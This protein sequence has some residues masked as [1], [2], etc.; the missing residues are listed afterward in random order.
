MKKNK[1]AKKKKKKNA[2]KKKDNV[3]RKND[4]PAKLQPVRKSLRT[5]SG[6]TASL[7]LLLLTD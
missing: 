6:K 1:I 7:P 5:R 2:E 3:K 4:Q